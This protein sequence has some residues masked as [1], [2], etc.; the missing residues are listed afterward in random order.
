[1]EASRRLP[2]DR[3]ALPSVL[4]LPLPVRVSYVRLTPFSPTPLPCAKKQEYTPASI[5]ATAYFPLFPTYS[6]HPLLHGHPSPLPPFAVAL[7]KPSLPIFSAPHY[8]AV[9]CYSSFSSAPSSVSVGSLVGRTLSRFCGSIAF[10]SLAPCHFLSPA[11]AEAGKENG[12]RC[13]GSC[14]GSERTC[15]VASGGL[16]GNERGAAVLDTKRSA[17]CSLMPSSLR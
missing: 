17:L 2:A 5:A 9:Q 15:F 6:L 12:Q 7:R 1:M 16:N 13:E 3:P 11:R 4:S 10:S 8:S 14:E